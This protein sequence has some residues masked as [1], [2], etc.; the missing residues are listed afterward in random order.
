[1]HRP[2]EN[3][4]ISFGDKDDVETNWEMRQAKVLKK[5]NMWKE[6]RLSI[7]GKVLVIKADILPALL[8]VAYVFPMQA[9]I[10]FK[11]QKALLNFLWGGYEYI[12]RETLYQPIEIG[13]RDFPNL[14]LKLNVLFFQMSVKEC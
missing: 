5:L 7:S 14:R 6:R 9:L 12:K 10:C 3:L 8:H 1:M 4:G 13:G 2:D 11:L